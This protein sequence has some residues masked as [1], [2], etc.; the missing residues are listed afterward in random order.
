MDALCER[1]TLIG[2]W[3]NREPDLATCNLGVEFGQGKFKNVFLVIENARSLT[4]L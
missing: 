4:H 3:R 2:P 1:L